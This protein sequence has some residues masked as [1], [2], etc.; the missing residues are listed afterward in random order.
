MVNS[1]RRFFALFSSE[2]FMAIGLVSPN[3]LKVNRLPEIPLSINHLTTELAL[4]L[5]N[6]KFKSSS[7]SL[8]V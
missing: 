3:P 2:L 8:S 4:S 7:P 6:N 5:D 1:V